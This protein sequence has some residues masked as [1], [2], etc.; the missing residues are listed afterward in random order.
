MSPT[1][2]CTDGKPEAGREWH[3]QNPLGGRGTSP[4]ILISAM[5]IECPVPPL[6][7]FNS[8]QVEDSPPRVRQHL[9]SP[10]CWPFMNCPG[11]GAL[12]SPS[13]AEAAAHPWL[14][15]V[16]PSVRTGDSDS[17]LLS[18]AWPRLPVGS[19]EG[20]VLPGT[21]VRPRSPRAREAGCFLSS[22]GSHH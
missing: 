19:V 4:N 3:A 5:F 17:L 2:V 6:S 21:N 12:L 8:K 9:S 7:M 10:C 14:R 20:S 13:R 15:P 18:Q 11:K 22:A 1:P 16:Q